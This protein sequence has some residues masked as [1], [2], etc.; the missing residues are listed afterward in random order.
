MFEKVRD[1]IVE[2]LDVDKENIS[3]TSHIINDLDA[4]SLDVVELVMALEETFDI[5]VDDDSVQSLRTVQD[6][7][8]YIEANQ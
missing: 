7:V 8:D 1:V 6:V 5:K 4:D 2:E 3:E